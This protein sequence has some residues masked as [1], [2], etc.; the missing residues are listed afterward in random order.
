MQRNVVNGVGNALFLWRPFALTWVISFNDFTG[1]LTPVRTTND[2]N[3]PTDLGGDYGSL[4]YPGFDPG[5]VLFGNGSVKPFVTDTHAY[6]IRPPARRRTSHPC[7]AS[8][9]SR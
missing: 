7:L 8:R 4:P 9:S 3:L 1:Y 5:L 6:G 2:Y